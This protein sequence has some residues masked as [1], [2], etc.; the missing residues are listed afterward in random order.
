MEA[1]PH[2]SWMWL[3]ELRLAKAPESQGLRPLFEGSRATESTPNQDGRP[4]NQTNI[5]AS[6]HGRCPDA[7]G[8]SQDKHVGFQ[9]SL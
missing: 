2:T 6:P 5:L 4:R 7:H 8:P 9:S 3:T 1:S